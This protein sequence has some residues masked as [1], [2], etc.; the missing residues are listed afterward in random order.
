MITFYDGEPEVGTPTE[1]P[2]EPAP[3]STEEGA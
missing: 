2:V 1:T 3:E